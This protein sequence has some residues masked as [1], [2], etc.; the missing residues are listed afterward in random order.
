MASA[1][2]FFYRCDAHFAVLFVLLVSV[3]DEGGGKRDGGILVGLYSSTLPSSDN[4]KSFLTIDTSNT[5]TIST[6]VILAEE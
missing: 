3:G 6:H 2:V 4:L 5:K 1:H